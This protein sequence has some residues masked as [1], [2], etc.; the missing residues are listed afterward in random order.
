MWQ[1]AYSPKAPAVT[2]SSR[3]AG[4]SDKVSM[5]RRP[6]STAW[7][8]VSAML[9]LACL[10]TSTPAQDEQAL[11]RLMAHMSFEEELTTGQELPRGWNKS[12]LPGV[13]IPPGAKFPH[14]VIGRLDTSR[15][16]DGQASFHLGLDGGNV[17]YTF[18]RGLQAYSDSDYLIVG[19]VRTS[20]LNVAR[21]RLQAQLVDP[22]GVAVAETVRMTPPM[23]Q[24]DGP[25]DQA[26]QRFELFVPGGHPQ[27]TRLQITLSLLQ[28]AI[29]RGGPDSSI[30]E[31][32]LKGQAWWDDISV[33]RLPRIRIYTDTPGNLFPEG[34]QPR[35]RLL[36]EGLDYEE[37]GVVLSILTADGSERAHRLIEA[38]PDAPR[39]RDI[40]LPY[41]QPGLYT[42]RLDITAERKLLARRTCT[43][44]CLAPLRES[45]ESQLGIDLQSVPDAQW[46]LAIRLAHAMRFSEL[47]LPVWLDP[48]LADSAVVNMDDQQALVK[49][50]E[51]LQDLLVIMHRLGITPS[52]QF[53]SLPWDLRSALETQPTLFEYLARD[54]EHLREAVMLAFAR[55]G[56]QAASWQIGQTY[57]DEAI[58]NPSL[59]DAYRNARAWL[60]DMLATDKMVLRW[61]GGIEYNL[62]EPGLLSLRIDPE[63]APEEIPD[64]L[65]H[66]PAM[67][68]DVHLVAQPPD[69]KRLE[70]LADFALRYAYTRVGGSRRVFIDPPWTQ[71]PD[72]QI[73]PEEIIFPA[74]TLAA[75]LGDARCLGVAR[76]STSTIAILFARS[77]GEGLVVAY[78]RPDIAPEGSVKI[79]LADSAYLVDLWGRRSE[80]PRDNDGR[81]ILHPSYVPQ[82]IAGCSADV[83]AFRA[84]LH[85]E[86]ELIESTYEDHVATLRF[87]NPYDQPVTGQMEIGTPEGWEI[88]PR[89]LSFSLPPG[90]EW[91]KDVLVRFPYSEPAGLKQLDVQVR[92]EAREG[93]Y[94]QA[95]AFF[96]LT[97]RDVTLDTLHTI[98]AEGFLEVRMIVINH[99]DR[100]VSFNC[101]AKAPD[102]AL[103]RGI[104]Q[105]LAPGAKA[106]KVFRFNNGWQLRGKELRTYI[107]ETGGG[108]GI[109]NNATTIR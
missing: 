38:S 81:A 84:S 7:M 25:A 57:D 64:Q 8:L 47:K 13:T 34:I 50:Y 31:Q 105:K 96:F 28:P 4:T 62:T 10:A 95:P 26:W 43:F 69:A 29:W 97:M 77:D 70:R 1:T 107:R 87:V 54:D 108:K 30:Y 19:Y 79:D 39:I 68:Y 22:R 33:Y 86:P 17:A 109:L 100:P 27:A 24:P 51:N 46:R 32:D 61:D 85:L 106:V 59:T 89:I 40:P 53:C 15:A 60:R 9:A 3:Q 23:G 74:S 73:V 56:R 49:M 16:H 83:L 37:A 91:R 41:L 82:I 35:L 55:F 102:R 75:Y 5:A 98:T 72:G 93:H 52:L 11:R 92:L 21:A 103:Q 14:Y 48:T 65:P 104:I 58:W 94:I 78:S 36:L 80:I 88:R 45:G 42:A 66:F 44:A 18:T 63:T 20:K 67:V 6:P 101:F 2:G 71:T 12:L 99:G 90:E 76:L